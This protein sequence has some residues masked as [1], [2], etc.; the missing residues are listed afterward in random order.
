MEKA[1]EDTVQQPRRQGRDPGS[2][3]HR[4]TLR[5][6]HTHTLS[7]KTCEHAGPMASCL[8]LRQ[9]TARSP[10]AKWHITLQLNIAPTFF[11]RHPCLHEGSVTRSR[12]SRM[13]NWTRSFLPAPSAQGTKP[14]RDQWMDGALL[15]SCF[16]LSSTPLWP[17]LSLV[18]SSDCC[19]EAPFKVWKLERND[20]E[21]KSNCRT[22]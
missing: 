6:S 11:C 7:T 22:K 20:D 10:A 12:L 5:V 13:L 17:T 19:L 16:L 14:L 3:P 2:G 9:T 1:A 4:H 21:P 18:M 8:R 15:R